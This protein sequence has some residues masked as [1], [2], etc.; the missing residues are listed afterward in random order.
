MKIVSTLLAGVAALTIASAAHSADME[1]K[2]PKG[3]DA[4]M[5]AFDGSTWW[6]MFAN[7]A[8]FYAAAHDVSTD[9]KYKPRF[10]QN[11]NHFATIASFRFAKDN[12]RPMNTIHKEIVQVADEMKA[13]AISKNWV[14]DIG[15]RMRWLARCDG[16]PAKYEMIVPGM[17]L[18]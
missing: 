8:G 6:E 3:G 11:R 13:M 14:N 16:L 9:S 18:N 5:E 2:H 12:N 15:S 4:L 7:C 17:L 10:G 1:Y